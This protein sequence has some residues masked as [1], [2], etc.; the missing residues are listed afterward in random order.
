MSTTTRHVWL[1]WL[2]L[3]SNACLPPLGVGPLSSLCVAF[4]FVGAWILHNISART[5]VYSAIHTSIEIF[6]RETGARNQFKVPPAGQPVLFV[7]AP[8][9]NQFLDPFVVSSLTGRSDCRFLTAAKTVR[10]RFLGWM[11]RTLGSIPVERSQD[12]AREGKGTVWISPED[13]TSVQGRGTNFTAVLGKGDTLK[14]GD[15]SAP[16]AEVVSDEVLRLAKPQAAGPTD[17][18]PY[19]ARAAGTGPARACAAPRAARSRRGHLPMAAAVREPRHSVAPAQH[20]AWPRPRVAVAHRKLP[21]TPCAGAAAM[22]C[23]A[24]L[25]YAMPC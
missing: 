2:A 15:V 16:V 25:C 11:A 3:A 22:R 24:M 20:S 9:H 1:L 18:L 7:C 6:F 17:W 14:F 12:I 21:H 5:F 4:V 23:Y 10:L 8:H 13:G 19:K